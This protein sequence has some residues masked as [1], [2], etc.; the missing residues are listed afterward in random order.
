MI[1]SSICGDKI[2]FHITESNKNNVNAFVDE[3]YHWNDGIRSYAYGH[4]KIVQKLKKTLEKAL[5]C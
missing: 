1:G 2:V 4:I 5:K 3:R